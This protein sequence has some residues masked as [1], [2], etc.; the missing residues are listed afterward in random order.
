MTQQEAEGVDP[1]GVTRQVEQNEG[2]RHDEHGARGAHL[3]VTA[4]VR[5]ALAHAERALEE[6][7]DARHRV[8]AAHVVSVRGERV[9]RAA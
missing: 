4:S 5:A 6:T 2:G 7:R 3:E 9:T 1:E 8:T